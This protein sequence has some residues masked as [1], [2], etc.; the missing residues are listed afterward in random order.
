MELFDEAAVGRLNALGR[1][2]RARI[3]EAISIARIPASVTGVGSMF[4]IHLKPSAPT[5]YRSAF[6]T[7]SQKRAL[8][9]LIDELYASG[10]LLINTA[11]GTLSTPMQEA[12]ID[13]LAESVLS[14]LR[15][16]KELLADD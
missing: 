7:P 1:L 12:D 13:H 3:K 6:P 2:T 4:R 5:D 11:S 9:V 10:I 14:G 15:K 8:N 16:A